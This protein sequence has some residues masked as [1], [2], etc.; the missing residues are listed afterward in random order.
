MRRI[1][2]NDI[3]HAVSHPYGQTILPDAVVDSHCTDSYNPNMPK[4]VESRHRC[5]VVTE[6]YNKWSPKTISYEQIFDA[7]L[8]LL[9]NVVGKVGKGTLIEPPFNPDYGC[10]TIVGSG[11][12]INFKLVFRR[13]S[14]QDH[15][16]L[17]CIALA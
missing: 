13:L 15:T 6:D 1:R 4:L 10:N 3:W 17:I 7:R 12:F 5:R 16:K 2:K 11:C 14:L 9:K 8:S